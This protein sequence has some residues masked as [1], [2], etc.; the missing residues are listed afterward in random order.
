[1]TGVGIDWLDDPHDWRDRP[2]ARPLHLA[3]CPCWRPAPP[4][5]LSLLFRRRRQ[6]RG[7]Q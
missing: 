6:G 7:V 4:S 2:G 5:L 1:V 3:S